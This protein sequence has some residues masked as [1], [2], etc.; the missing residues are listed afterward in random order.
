MII[1][2]AAVAA[3]CTKHLQMT[4]SSRAVQCCS[5]AVLQCPGHG[6]AH[7]C[8]SQFTIYNVHCSI[9]SAAAAAPLC[10]FVWL[11]PAAMKHKTHA[12]PLCVF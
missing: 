3:V 9:C 5:A 10:H 4:G 1:T 6:G 12:L 7:Q 8:N 2:N 11:P